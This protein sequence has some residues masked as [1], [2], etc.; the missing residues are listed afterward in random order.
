MAGL[1]L[2]IYIVLVVWALANALSGR[3]ENGDK[4]AW[5]ITIIFVPFLGAIL[6]FLIGRH[7][8]I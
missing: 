1:I 8:K 3:F 5:V 2:L 6:Y 4:T 7:Q